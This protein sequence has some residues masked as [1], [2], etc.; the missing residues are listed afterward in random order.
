M[1]LFLIPSQSINTL[2]FKYLP[3]SHLGFYLYFV[4]YELVVRISD[5][6]YENNFVIINILLL[7][8]LISWEKLVMNIS[9][10]ILKSCLML[11]NS[12]QTLKTK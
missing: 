5:I 7:Q 6:L 10:E 11:L 3:K 2:T 1:W 9:H 8:W 12:L 4:K